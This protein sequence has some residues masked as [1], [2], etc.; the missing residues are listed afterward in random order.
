MWI[1]SFILSFQITEIYNNNNNNHFIKIKIQKPI[2]LQFRHSTQFTLHPK[3]EKKKKRTKE[4]VNKQNQ[5]HQPIS[6]KHKDNP[7]N[8]SYNDIKTQKPHRRDQMRMI[9]CSCW[10]RNH[11]Q[12]AILGTTTAT[13]TERKG[14]DDGARGQDEMKLIQGRRRSE[15]EWGV[16]VCESERERLRVG[17]N[18]RDF[19][20]ESFEFWELLVRS[21]MKSWF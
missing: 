5:Q 13:E 2:N 21:A 9:P 1:P 20:F 19:C 17:G 11:C 10:D 6:L 7:N 16:R 3:K 12:K 15:M 8:H 18:E 14:D 4:T